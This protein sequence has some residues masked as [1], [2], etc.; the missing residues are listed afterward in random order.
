MYIYMYVYMYV[1][2]YIFTILGL[3][4]DLMC[5]HNFMVHL[6]LKV[7]VGEV[8]EAVHAMRKTFWPT[9]LPLG[10]LSGDWAVF[11]NKNGKDILWEQ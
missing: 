5:G 1:H 7:L 4:V 11:S 6:V 10:G 8:T 2:I 3:Q 9:R